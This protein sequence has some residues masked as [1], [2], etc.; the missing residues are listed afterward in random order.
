V[1]PPSLGGTGES[2]EGLN[3]QAGEGGGASSTG[4][5][6]TGLAKW[7]KGLVQGETE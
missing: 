7:V 3:P 2:P 1:K 6:G 4:S 5:E